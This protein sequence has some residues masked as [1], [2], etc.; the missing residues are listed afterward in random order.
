MDLRVVCQNDGRIDVP[1]ENLTAIL[2]YGTD[3]VDM[4]MTCPL[5]GEDIHLRARIPDL[6]VTVMESVDA[7]ELEPARRLRTARVMEERVDDPRFEGYIAYFHR[8]L[9]HADT[10]DAMLDEIDG[11]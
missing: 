9:E 2:I 6:L 1:V 7:L 5:C 10:V 3:V 8:Q 4:V 11:R